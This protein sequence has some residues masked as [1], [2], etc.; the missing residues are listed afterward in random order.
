MQGKILIIDGISTNRIVLKVKLTAA[1]YE[2][3]QAGTLREAVDVINAETPD[4][5][6][7]A[8]NL[9]DG[10]AAQLCEHLRRNAPTAN[11]PVLAI[12]IATNAQTRMVTLRAGAFDVMDKPVNETLL[13]GR[14]RN[15]IRAHHKLAEWQ[16]RED[17][18]D[19]LGFAEAPPEFVVPGVIS[20]IGTDAGAL[21]GWVRQLLPHLRASY[22]VTSLRDAMATLHAGKPP[23]AV[24]LALPD[25]AEQSEACLRLVS[26]LRASAPT[27]DIAVLMIQRTPDPARAISALDLGADDVMV[28]PFDPREVALRLQVLLRRKRQVARM[29]QSVRSGLRQVVNDPLTG[30]YNRRYAMPFMARMIAHSARTQAHFA[31]LLADLDHFKRVN[32]IYGHASGDAVLA[33]TA[34]RMQTAV[35]G[36]DMIARMGGEEFMIAMPDANIATARNVADRLCRAV[37][38]EPFIVPGAAQPIHITISIGLAMNAPSQTM[39]RRPEDVDALL[40]RADKALYAAK[41]QGRNCVKLSRPLDRPAA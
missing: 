23:D 34:R 13:L 12:G 15:M 35:R 11:L 27:R 30:L 41:V 8:I 25:T 40:D 18:S 28:F 31:V 24:V 6:I 14:V 21:Q 4:L 39:E 3:I 1:F 17:T 20:L 29:V 32:D 33:E 37:G 9:P 19:A 36:A 38:N 22:N 2:V 26:G 5:V 7:T 10:T 16:M